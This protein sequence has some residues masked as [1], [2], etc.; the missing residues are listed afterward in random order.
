MDLHNL[1]LAHIL[2]QW[3]TPRPKNM[4][5]GITPTEQ[6][7]RQM[8]KETNLTHCQNFNRLSIYGDLDNFKLCFDFPH[9]QNVHVVRK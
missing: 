4:H 9:I 6:K 1:L 7:D 8:G 2:P 3:A 5:A